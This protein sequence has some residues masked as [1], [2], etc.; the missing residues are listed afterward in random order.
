MKMKSSLY[1]NLVIVVMFISGNGQVLRSPCPGTFD[2]E[3][4]GENFYGVIHLL[5]KNKV[6]TVELKANFSIAAPLYSTYLGRLEPDGRTNSLN[7]LNP[8]EML[9]YNVHFPIQNPIPKL[10]GLTVNGHIICSGE[11]DHPLSGQTT[12]WINLSHRIFTY[13]SVPRWSNVVDYTKYTPVYQPG[14][15][16]YPY[17]ATMRTPTKPQFQPTPAAWL[18]QTPPTPAYAT[19]ISPPRQPYIENTEKTYYAPNPIPTPVTPNVERS[20]E[21]T[22]TQY[23]CGIPTINK[24]LI[25]NGKEYLRGSYPWLVALSL[26]KKQQLKFICAGT[27]VS[28]RHVVTAAHC[29]RRGDEVNE[30]K[31]FVVTAGAY[32]LD[33]LA[34][35]EAKRYYVERAI[36]YIDYDPYTFKNDIMI[37]TLKNNVVFSDYIIP[38]CLWS[39]KYADLN[40]IVGRYGTIAGWGRNERHE[41]GIG[42]PLKAKLPIVSTEECRNSHKKF[43]KITSDVTICAGGKD[44]VSPCDGDSGGGLY[45]RYK[46]VREEEDV[47]K[48]LRLRGV[49]SL[50][51]ENDDDSIYDCNIKEYVR[52]QVIQLLKQEGG[53]T[54]MSVSE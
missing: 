14:D 40:A 27:L 25:V 21:Q 43:L 2:Y 24:V 46:G 33:N 28:D 42:K 44:D 52:E 54:H 16:F 6:N 5:L 17:G 47:D 30:V 20:S 9:I 26:Q 41:G 13:S 12:S 31:Q 8:G 4:D 11:A 39:E 34:D 37:L 18:P 35:N 7:Q 49:V 3:N 36:P 15:V 51:L 23:Q 29:Q 45:L 48:P 32:D 19:R 22:S 53:D 1:V 10:T 50:S 38:I